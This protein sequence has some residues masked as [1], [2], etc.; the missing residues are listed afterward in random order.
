VI[1]EILGQIRTIAVAKGAGEVPV[2]GLVGDHNPERAEIRAARLTRTFCRHHR[3]RLWTVHPRYLDPRGLVS[4]IHA[5]ATARRYAFDAAK[6][7]PVRVVP[8]IP[9]TTGQ[10]VYEWRHLLK[11]LAVRNPE[12][13][14]RWRD[15][16]VRNCTRSSSRSTDRAHHGN[17]DCLDV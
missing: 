15:V 13:C 1:D 2:V 7:G 6:V 4:A 9:A 3:T 8:K 10:V 14:H 12:W 11:K 5:E 17:A 16:R